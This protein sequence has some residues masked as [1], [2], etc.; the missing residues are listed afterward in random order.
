MRIFFRVAFLTLLALIVSLSPIVSPSFAVAAAVGDILVADPGSGTVR[1]FS[2]SGD[3]LGVFASGF[4]SLTMWIAADR[5]GN[6]YV[7]EQ[8]GQRISKLSTTGASLTIPIPYQPGGVQV[9]ADGTIYVAD[10]LGG[11]IYHYSAALVFLDQIAS[12]QL[13]QSYFMAF[14]AGGIL[15]VTDP[16][17]GV[18]HSISPATGDVGVFVDGFPGPGGGRIRRSRELVRRQLQRGLHRKIL[19]IATGDLCPS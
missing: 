13:G 2:A 17:L 14:D 5:M 3:Y 10:R 7:S 1:H 16:L 9:G 11:T 19:V 18:V 12:T 6:V 8:D 15:Y 4:N